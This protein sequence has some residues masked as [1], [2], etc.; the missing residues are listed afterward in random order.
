MSSIHP[1]QA[2]D[3]TIAN[4]P[5]V[6]VLDGVSDIVF[7]KVPNAMPDGVSDGLLDGKTPCDFSP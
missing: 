4:S 7:D 1:T 3:I 2:I 6:L 5:M